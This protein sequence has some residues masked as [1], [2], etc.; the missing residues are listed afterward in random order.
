MREREGRRGKRKDKLAGDGLVKGDN[1][2]RGE[3][4]PRVCSR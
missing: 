1:E 3:K 4:I 2:G